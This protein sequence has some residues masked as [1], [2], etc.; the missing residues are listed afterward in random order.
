M[1][2][3]RLLSCAAACAVMLSLTSCGGKNT[4]KEYIPPSESISEADS[5]P[6]SESG[7][8]SESVSDDSS[9]TSEPEDPKTEIYDVDPIVLAYHAND[10]SGLE[11][12]DAEIYDKACE[13]IGEIITDDMTDYEKELAVHDYIVYNCTYDKGALAAIPIHSENCDN[14]YGA[15]I[16]ESA[17]CLGYTT[18]FRLFM[19][20]LGIPCGTVHS[21]DTDGDE[22]AWNTVQLD[23]SW[24][25]VDVTWD[26]PVPDHD[27]RLI[28]HTYFNVTRDKIAEEHILPENAPETDSIKYSY[29]NQSA[30]YVSDMEQLKQAISDAAERK[31]NSAVV[32]LDESF[33]INFKKTNTEGIYRA[34]LSDD[35]GKQLRKTLKSLG[36]TYSG[37]RGA[38]TENGIATEVFFFS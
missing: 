9:Q 13:I 37:I 4:E 38:D 28:Y 29:P 23:G 24:Y 5:A 11:G 19:G 10:P 30:V 33:G 15:L 16:N 20:M 21:T 34:T 1:D 12:I 3:K 14:P 18:T 27:G 26:D 17:I 32:I 7:S 6:D 8:D 31:A 35:F 36:L 2:K 22:H 25:Y